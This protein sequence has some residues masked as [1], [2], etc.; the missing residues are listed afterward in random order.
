MGLWGQWCRCVQGLRPACRRTRTFGWLVLLLAGLSIRGDLAGVSSVIRAL[1]LKGAAYR[2]LLALCHSP[3]LDLKRLTVCWTALVWRLFT[4]LRLG[5]RRVLV[6][7][8]LKVAREGKKMPAVKKLHQSS[9]N[10][11]KAEYIFGHSFQALGLLAQGPNGH[12][13]CVPLSSRIHE[14]LVFSNRDRRT[15]LD[16]FVALFLGLAQGVDETLLLVVDAYYASRKVLRPLLARDH[17][18]LTRLRSNAVAYQPAR[19][20]RQPRRGRPR[21]YGRKVRL[22]ELW[23]RRRQ[24]FCTAPSP[25]YGEQQVLI[26]YLALDL[27]WRPLGRLV[28]FVL[29][30]HP[31]RG[32]LML[33]CTD[34]NLPPL[35]IIAGYG[36]RFKIELAFKQALHTLGTYSYHFWMKAMAPRP[37]GNGNQYLHRA[38]ADYRRQVRRKIE[39]YH[40]YVQIGCIAQGLL[41]Y[42]A[43][44]FQANVW[45][46]FGSWLRTMNPALPPSEAVVAQALRHTLAEFLVACPTE[47]I[48][49]KF[50]LPQA[51][52]ERCPALP[53]AA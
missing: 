41:Q 12:L 19:R 20:P 11:S 25:V 8:G 50:L 33:M 32:R 10:N 24:Q 51:D 21:L 39:A 16:K 42:L 46:S 34:L 26:R 30:E 6:G 29:V 47:A 15:L 23:R 17:Q 53:R 45:C 28:R 3:A 14:G 7:D 4:P 40:R 35:E 49:A 38:S 2:R 18:V 1:G 48:L 13:C 9:Q 44:S 5:G 36:Y 52:P 31:R 27:L 37:T 43:L 22:R